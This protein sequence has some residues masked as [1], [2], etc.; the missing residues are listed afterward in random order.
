MK[1]ITMIF[2]LFSLLAYGKEYNIGDNI[3]L[4]IQGD[5]SK[6]QIEKAFKPYKNVDI[7]KSNNEYIVSFTSYKVGVNKIK[8][9]NTNLKIDIKSTLT[10]KDKELKKDLANKENK[11]IIKDYPYK[12]IGSFIVGL[13][14]IILSIILFILKRN[15]DP[16]NIYNKNIKNINMDKWKDELSY[17]LRNY[18]DGEYKSSFLNG[19]YNLDK[20]T[21]E[22][23]EFIKK[24]D[25]L[26]FSKNSDNDYE[27]YKE[28]SM[29]IIERLRKERK[30]D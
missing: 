28:K 16:F 24:L 13:F 18:I 20:L 21:F 5:I 25:Y 14:L 2:L 1:K 6:N 26:K 7:T 12:T 8:I 19:E 29:E 4:K 23:I 10:K 11:F 22:D 30:N 27:K 9:G 17:S 15:R 3:T